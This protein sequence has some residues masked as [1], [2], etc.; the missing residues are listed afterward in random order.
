MKSPACRPKR[1][2]RNELFPLFVIA[3]LSSALLFAIPGE[4]IGFSPR[5]DAPPLSASCSFVKLGEEEELK[6]LATAQSAWH[7]SSRGVKELRIEMF[8]DSPPPSE[9]TE[10]LPI[11]SRALPPPPPSPAFEPSTVP[12]TLA[13]PAP[14]KIPSEP[15]D[16]ATQTF[17]RE[18]LLRID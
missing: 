12:K 15:E 13:A 7:V 9:K 4:A 5:P 18:A 10:V 2:L 17:S 6:A 8:A 16:A 11:S 3:A 1:R 14:V